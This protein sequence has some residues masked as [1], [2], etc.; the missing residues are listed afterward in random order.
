[1]TTKI[2][3]IN[4]IKRDEIFDTLQQGSIIAYP[5]DTIYGIGADI[6]QSDAVEKLFSTKDRD[7]SKPVS[8]LYF[9]KEKVLAD[10][11]HLSDYEKSFITEF[12]PG[13]MTLILRARENDQFPYPFIKDGMVGIRV[14]DHPKLNQ[15]MKNYPNPITT[16]SINPTGEQPAESVDEIVNYFPN[17]FSLII[18][19]GSTKN[20]G[21]ST[22]LLL[23]DNGYKIL[24]ES[25]ITKAEIEK[26]IPSK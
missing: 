24:R 23:S 15:L 21:A 10:F 19:D 1:M 5:T 8:L 17:Q 18:N 26:R 16:T 7:Y 6:Y 22:V 13:A 3:A 12:L 4:D 14:I 20:K 9:S 11:A 25:A 2:I